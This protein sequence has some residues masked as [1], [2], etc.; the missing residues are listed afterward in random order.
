LAAEMFLYTFGSS[1]FSHQI[2][3]L[4]ESELSGRD[5]R[6]IFVAQVYSYVNGLSLFT[7]FFLTR[8]ILSQFNPLIGL[9]FL[10]LIQ[11]IGSLGLLVQPSLTLAAGVFVIRYAVN[12]STGRAVRE[13]LYTPMSRVEKYQGKGFIDTLV[14]RAGDGLGSLFLLSGLAVFPYGSW[15]SMAILGTMGLSMM[16]I[17]LLTRHYHMVLLSGTPVGSS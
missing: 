7:Q 3:V 16:V 6:T 12:Y 14:F 5:Q 8:R 15:V 17:R 9:L 2:N 1:L 13:L 11:A 10:P 4:M